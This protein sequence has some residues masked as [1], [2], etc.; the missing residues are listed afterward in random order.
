MY[1]LFSLYIYIDPEVCPTDTCLEPLDPSSN[2]TFPLLKSLFNEISSLFPDNYIHLGG[3]EVSMTC[4]N[5]TPRIKQWMNDHGYD[6][7]DTYKYMIDNSHQIILNNNKKTMNWEEVVTHIP[8]G[9]NNTESIIQIW[10]GGTSTLSIIN[11]GFNVLISKKWYLDD[12]NNNWEVFY[13]NDPLSGV[14]D[15]EKQ[16]KVLG[17][18]ACMWGETVDSS[19]IFN[20]IWPR[21]AS[22]SERL[23]TNPENLNVEKAKNRLLWFRCLLN[24]RG[25]EAAP[26]LNEVGRSAPSE[27]GGCLC[28]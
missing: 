16:K 24:E 27:A 3:D 8:K 9:I 10:L 13:N 23:W 12:L 22:V 14:D 17:G 2:Y 20:T 25:I 15:K 21:A 4:W 18:E 5:E 7:T 28:Q 11:R 6:L 1:I 26:V 19:D